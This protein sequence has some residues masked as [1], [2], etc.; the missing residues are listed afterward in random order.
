MKR[1]VLVAFIVATVVLYWAVAN[2]NSAKNV[3]NKIDNLASI[4]VEYYN[5]AI[6]ELTDS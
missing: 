1:Y 4:C 5:S 6:D 2:P 3:R